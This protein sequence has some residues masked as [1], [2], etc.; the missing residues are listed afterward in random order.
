MY[1]AKI[2]LKIKKYMI[3]VTIITIGM[4][5]SII[6]C[7]NLHINFHYLLL[8]IEHNLGTSSKPILTT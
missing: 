1:T 5:P 6:D 7:I 3:T 8:E 4:R 2:Y